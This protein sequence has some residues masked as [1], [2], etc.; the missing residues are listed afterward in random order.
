MHGLRR[1]PMSSRQA[2]RSVM[3]R[4][5]SSPS[6]P[7]RCSSTAIAGSCASSGA[8]TSTWTRRRLRTSK[9]LLGSTCRAAAFPGRES[10]RRHPP[11][12]YARPKRFLPKPRRC[13]AAIRRPRLHRRAP[14]PWL[15]RPRNRGRRRRRGRRRS[16]LQRSRSRS[17]RPRRSRC[18]HRNLL[19]FNRRQ[20]RLQRLSHHRPI[21]TTA[22][23]RPTTAACARCIDQPTQR[24][25]RR[26]QVALR[27]LPT[28][29][30]R[31]RRPKA[32]ARS[33]SIPRGSRAAP[34]TRGERASSSMVRRWM[35]E[36]SHRSARRFR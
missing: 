11:I 18:R 8:G 5:A 26:P 12:A 2:A 1:G 30:R 27:F 33:K 19:P 20:L 34:T 29:R 3:G 32:K 10:R 21:R 23:R 17:R 9:S 31:P 28:R 7:T 24:S 14:C 6:S 16:R 22:T 35:A 36:G 15:L 4:S 25:S 13:A